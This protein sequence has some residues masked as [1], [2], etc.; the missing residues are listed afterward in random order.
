MS[1]P[2]M[3]RMFGFFPV[4]C[5]GDCAL[6]LPGLERTH[7]SARLSTVRMSFVFMEFVCCFLNW[8]FCSVWQ[9][10]FPIVFHADDGPA[11]G[12]GFT[13]SV[14][15]CSLPVSAATNSTGTPSHCAE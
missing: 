8:L 7:I 1:S 13:H 5:A 12:D 14:S 11:F 15:R 2:Q 9:N 4:D 6:V 10:R 3:T